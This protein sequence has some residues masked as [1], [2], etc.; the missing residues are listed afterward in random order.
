[1]FV[2]A[3][4]DQTITFDNPPDRTIGDPPFTLSAN[5]SSGLL[6]TFSVHGNC[7]VAGNVVTL[8]QAGSC[9][10]TA[11]QTGSAD[12]NPAPDVTHLFTINGVK[13]FLALIVRNGN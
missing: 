10:V 3:K 8:T 7:S 12:Y 4:A 13:V 1:M 2:I 11:H 9:S 5:A 6:T